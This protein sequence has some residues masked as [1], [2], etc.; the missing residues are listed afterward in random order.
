MCTFDVCQG[1]FDICEEFIGACFINLP[2][3]N[4]LS[5]LSSSTYVDMD[6]VCV[7]LGF[8][9]FRFG[10]LI[11]KDGVLVRLGGATGG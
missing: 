2:K 6:D 4:S 8:R 9:I 5:W 7:K 10:F 3:V 1:G 11:K